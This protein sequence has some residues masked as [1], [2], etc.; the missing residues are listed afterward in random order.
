MNGFDETG[1]SIDEAGP[2]DGAGFVSLPAA[3]V[4]LLDP[5]AGNFDDQG[6][7]FFDGSEAGP[8]VVHQNPKRS[9]QYALNPKPYTTHRGAKADDT[10][11]IRGCGSCALEAIHS[12]SNPLK[13]KP[14]MTKRGA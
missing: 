3:P 14:G 7:F 12:E 5:A 4:G 13:P 11:P 6:T 8:E 9:K 1:Q 10:R 2:S